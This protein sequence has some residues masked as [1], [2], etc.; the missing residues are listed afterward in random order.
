MP[1]YRYHHIGIPT[2]DPQPGEEYNHTGKHF[3]AGYATSP[4]GVEWLRFDARCE[5]P[6]LIQRVPHVAFV[7]DDLSAALEG[8]EVLVPPNSPAEG[9]TVAFIVHNGAPIEFI[10]FDRPEAE[11]WPTTVARVV[12]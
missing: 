3:A 5:L 6:E 10:A 8:Q 4:Y 1:S 12:D 7:V 2:T 11:V 9:V